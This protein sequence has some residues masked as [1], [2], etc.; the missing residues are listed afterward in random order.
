MRY[1]WASRKGL[2]ESELAGILGDGDDKPLPKAHWTPFYLAADKSLVNRSGLIDFFHDHLRNAVKK[3]H[4]YS[5]KDKKEA[6]IHIARY[7]GIK[8]INARV[9]YE[10]PW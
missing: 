5:E 6:H 9:A 7:F 8:D 10:R 3:R 4:L 2:S 1:I